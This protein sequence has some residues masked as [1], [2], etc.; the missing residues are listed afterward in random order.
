M[1]AALDVR[2][3]VER[4]RGSGAPGYETLSENLLNKVRDRILRNTERSRE[5]MLPNR[6]REG[7]G[8]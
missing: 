4:L 2:G 6:D 3:Q 5:G 8:V 1:A 7:A